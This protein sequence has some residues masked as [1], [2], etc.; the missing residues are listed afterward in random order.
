MYQNSIAYVNKLFNEA[1]K[2]VTR[3]DT[4]DH[5]A[6]IKLHLAAITDQL[7]RK[8][9]VGLFEAHKLIFAF[10]MCTRIKK[11]S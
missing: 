3:P 10:L 6:L 4:D 9:C 7:Y 11:H 1:I 5:E 8:I 2:S